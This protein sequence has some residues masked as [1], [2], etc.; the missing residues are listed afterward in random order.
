MEI[1]DIEKLAKLARIHLSEDEKKTLL[2]DVDSIL[3]YV[4]VVQKITVQDK[5]EGFSMAF[6]KNVL[7]D[8]E[9]PNESGE[10][11]E[12]LLKSA[13]KREENYFKVKQIIE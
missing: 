8:D 7:R 10:C 4:K 11:S 2:K 6:S 3:E 5:K 9:N 13:P 1:K 12:D